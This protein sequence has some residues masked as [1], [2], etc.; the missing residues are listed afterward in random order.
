MRSPRPIR[1]KGSLAA[2]TLAALTVSFSSYT[3]AQT[4]TWD[5]GFDGID[6]AAD[7]VANWLRWDSAIDDDWTE[8]NDS[9]QLNTPSP[10]YMTVNRVG[11]PADAGKTGNIWVRDPILSYADGF[12]MEVT[13]EIKPDSE[14][15]AFSMTYLDQGGSFGV[16][17][18]PDSIKVGG[19]APTDPGNV[20]TY[21]TTNGFHTYWMEQLPN[22]HTVLLYVDGVLVDTGQ[23]N[24]NY[25]V[26]S[27]V[28]LQYP[29]VLI[30]DNSNDPSINA[31]YVLQNVEYRRGASS[32][33]QTPQSFPARV[34]PAPPAPAV[35]ETWTNGYYASSGNPSNTGWA[36][37]GGG[38]FTAQPDGSER[39]QGDTNAM[40][41]SPTGWTN[42]TALTV[43]ASLKVMPDCQ[44]NGFQLVANDT[45]GDMALVL[46]PDKVTLEEAYSFVGQAS[47][48][49]DTTN[50]FHTYRMT[51]DV[52]GLYWDLFIDNNPVAAISD[53]KSGGELIGFSRIWFGDI[54]F[55]NPGNTPDVEINYIRWHQGA[56]APQ[57][58][59]NVNLTWNNAG[60]SGNGTTWDIGVNA[61]WSQSSTPVT[62]T[63]GNNVTFNDT[64][65]GNYSVTLNTTV[66]P[67]SITVNN[68]AGNYTI[69][70]SGSIAGSGS[71]SKSGTGALTLDTVN[72]YTGQTSVSA[73]TLIAGVRGALPD[74]PL[75]I[76]GTGI[77]RLATNTGLATLSSL[78]ITGSGKLDIE[79]NHLIIT[80][81]GTSD[82]IATIASY[83]RQGYNGGH[84]TG[85]GID[86]L[87][88]LNNL[89][90]YGIGY[91]DAAD[92]GNPA[93]L[94]SG[95]IEVMYTL[96][97]DANLDGR[98]NGAD[99][100]ILA[101]NFNKAAIGWDQGDF[102]YDGAVNGADFAALASNFNQGASQADLAAVSAFSSAHGLDLST[103]IPE[104]G[105]LAVF[106][107]GGVSLLRRRTNKR[108]AV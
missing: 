84:W 92:P 56:N 50:A 41:N 30:G 99:F 40:L 51:R 67:S 13:A 22:S 88:A 21:N 103:N 70:G 80:Y 100:A 91:A 74:S 55:P 101:S 65:N 25:A 105:M 61:N 48:K 16:Q 6:S 94:A 17:L 33:T 52:D 60:G 18:S 57:S 93:G 106:A 58:P 1:R 108:R 66:S 49:M 39:I 10:G 8:P 45:F 75:S 68:G 62:Y 4:Q 87:A 3:Q 19:L 89:G 11:N 98:V 23:G 64:N 90:S 43:E 102:N 34:L 28:D 97:G 46:S 29:R 104:P 36:L 107:F 78:S 72:T 35:H 32:P 69:S 12:T 14:A 37:A 15:N 82:P 42:M 24:S 71:L 53:Q 96:L 27:N 31:D 73:G 44:E 7:N 59:Q 79:N 63:D 86:S 2:I 47:I 54:N 76:S 85:A 5:N 38:T 20:V 83:I 26:G 81:S 95:Q 77:V 9:F